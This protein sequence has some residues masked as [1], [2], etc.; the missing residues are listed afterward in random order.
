MQACILGMQKITVSLEKRHVYELE[1]RQRLGDAD[2]HYASREPR[3][4]SGGKRHSETA[5][6]LP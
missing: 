6:A 2:S 4:R 1:A 3:Y 5:L